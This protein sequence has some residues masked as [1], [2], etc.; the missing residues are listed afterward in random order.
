MDKGKERSKA[1]MELYSTQDICKM[2]KINR[3]KVQWLRESGLL[4]ARRIG[5]GFLTS[6]QELQEF[7]DYTQGMDISNEYKIKLAG[8]IKRA[9][10]R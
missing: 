10:D 9:N 6:D 1:T 7:L 5:K 8:Q 2:L 4:K 3:N